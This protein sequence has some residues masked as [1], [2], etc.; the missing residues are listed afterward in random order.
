MRAA[1]YSRKSI[2]TGKGE[3]LEN[4]VQMCK[5][6]GKTIGVTEYL[7]YEDEGFSG[8]NTDRP[9]FKILMGDAKKKKFDVLICYRLDRVSRNTAD[10]T[11]LI[12]SLQKLNIGFVS[13]REQFDTSSPMGRAMMNIAA[14]FA[15][16]ERETIAERVRDNMLQL[17]KTGR[18]LGGNPPLGFK[19]VR[20]EINGKPASYLEPVNEE[21]EVVKLVFKKYQELGSQYKVSKYLKEHNIAYR[22]WEVETIKRI[23]TAPN[24][25]AVDENVKKYCESYGITVI[26]EMNGNGIIPYNQKN[27]TNKFNPTTE[28]IYSVG[29]HKGIITSEE[30]LWC[31]K[32]R[33]KRREN[34]TYN[35][36]STSNRY[37][38]LTGMLKCAKCGESMRVT[39]G[40]K[41]KDGSRPLYYS[42]KKHGAYGGCTTSNIRMDKL[43]TEVINYLSNLKAPDINVEFKKADKSNIKKVKKSIEKNDIAIQ[44]LVKQ[45]AGL[46]AEASTYVVKELESLSKE[47]SVLKIKLLELERESSSK[48]LQELNSQIFLSQISNFRS[49]FEKCETLDDKRMLVRNI[50]EMIL[51]DSDT[52][53]LR[54][55][56]VQ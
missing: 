53:K 17:A 5:E 18:W 32:H 19:P 4:Q 21:L 26:G 9:Q 13:I 16:L 55:K 51:W 52:K 43:D 6:H 2:I 49:N 10:F 3:S 30:W 12:D 39:Y 25:V 48:D 11:A 27:G 31:Q 15:Q 22:A 28:W 29:Q 24:Y 1:I 33:W 23:I 34:A 54:Y 38:F 36:G 42:C 20:T 44:N 40:P 45:M 37:S 14:V 50:V 7:I 47:N 41:R 56:L 8:G 35:F 46:T